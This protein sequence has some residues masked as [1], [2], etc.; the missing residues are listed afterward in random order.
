VVAVLAVLTRPHLYFATT[1]IHATVVGF[2]W[3]HHYALQDKHRTCEDPDIQVDVG[4]TQVLTDRSENSRYF[5]RRLYRV[6][7][8]VWLQPALRWKLDKA[9]FLRLNLRQNVTIYENGFGTVVRV[10]FQ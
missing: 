7:Y 1:P 2:E 5:R 6:E 3:K 10:E 9:D 8:Y 4:T